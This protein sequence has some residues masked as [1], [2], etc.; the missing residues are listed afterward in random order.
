[1]KWVRRTY[2]SRCE[3][4]GLVGFRVKLKQTDLQI[5]AERDLSYIAKELVLK[6]RQELE[7]YIRR[8]RNFLES[9]VPVELLPGAGAIVR[10]MAEA[11]LA[12]GVGPMAAVAGAIAERVGRGLLKESREVIVENG[13]DLFISSNR[14]R[15]VAIF[16]GKSPL[17]MKLAIEIEPSETPIGLACSSATV[18]PS[19]SFGSADAAVAIASSAALADAAATGLGNRVRT[20]GDF[21][22]ALGW[23]LSIPGVRGALVVLGGELAAQGELKLAPLA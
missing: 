21:E 12:T 4:E 5:Y 8:D 15:R 13:G 10:D 22:R 3:P 1:M 23:A 17:S 9:L 19:I 7:D 11:A 14:T 16:A 2:R 20:R 18:G 6:A